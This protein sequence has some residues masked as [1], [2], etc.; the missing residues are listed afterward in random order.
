MTRRELVAAALAVIAWGAFAGVSVAT[1]TGSLP[2]GERGPAGVAGVQ[3][4]AG[5]PGPRGPRG[6]QG[7]AGAQ[8]PRGDHG[9]MGLC[10][11]EAYFPDGTFPCSDVALANLAEQVCGGGQVNHP[12]YDE[13]CGPPP[14]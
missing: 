3:G 10:D 5:A 6:Q 9:P 8:G 7:P 4:A 1:F 13:L 14:E 12:R 11:P 2:R